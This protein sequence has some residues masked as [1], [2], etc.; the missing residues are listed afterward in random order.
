MTIKILNMETICLCSEGKVLSLITV[1]PDKSELIGARDLSQ[2]IIQKLMKIDPLTIVGYGS[3][4]SLAIAAVDVSKHIA[5]VNIQSI[6]LD[7]IPL[8]STYTPEAIFLELSKKP[9]AISSL[10]KDFETQQFDDIIAKTIAVHRGDR[11]E[12]ITNQILWK[13]NRCDTIKVMASGFAIMTAIRS[14]LQ[15]TTSGIAKEQVGISAITIDSVERR[16]QMESNAPKRIPAIQIYLEKG[17]QTEYPPNHK[18]IIDKV[19]AS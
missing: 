14:T 9:S 18:E 10:V 2:D 12:T 4:I 11:V 5:N 6:S 13:L 19:T 3:S 17:K 15:I 1:T 7:Y 8:T 16:T